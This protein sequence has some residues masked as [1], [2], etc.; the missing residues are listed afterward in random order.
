MSLGEAQSELRLAGSLTAESR[1][2]LDYVPAERSTRPYIARHLQYL[3]QTVQRHIRTL[4]QASPEPD[5]AATADQCLTDLRQLSAEL[6]NAQ[7]QMKDAGGR[8]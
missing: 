5:A 8:S 2:F 7:Q 4:E 1:L 6:A 3:E